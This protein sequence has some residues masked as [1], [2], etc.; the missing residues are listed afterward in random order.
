MSYGL[1]LSSVHRWIMSPLQLAFGGKGMLTSTFAEGGGFAKTRQD[2]DIPDI[3]FHFYPSK[4]K[5]QMELNSIL[6]HGF[7][8]QTCLLRPKSRGSVT[9]RDSNPDSKVLIDPNYLAEEEDVQVF[10]DGFKLMR[11]ILNTAPSRIMCRRRSIRV[12]VKVFEREGE[13]DSLNSYI[14]RKSLAYKRSNSHARTQVQ[15][16]FK[17]MRRFEISFETTLRQS[18]IP[19][20][21]VEWALPMI[22][23]LWWIQDYVYTVFVDF[24]SR[25]LR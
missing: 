10:V 13:Y 2:K 6:G 8:L 17:P 18:S 24:A 3:Q 15:I 5:R 22:P 14:T 9:L 4:I 21:L 11:K 16:R 20:E 7:S 19:P 25:T 23:K 12:S 1:S